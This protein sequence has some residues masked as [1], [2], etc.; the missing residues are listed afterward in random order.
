MNKFTRGWGSSPDPAGGAY[1]VPPDTLVGWE[2]IGAYGA[3]RRLH[4][5]TFGTRQGA[6]GASVLPYHLYVRGAASE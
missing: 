6:C 3:G 4:S 1:D 2:G 5:R